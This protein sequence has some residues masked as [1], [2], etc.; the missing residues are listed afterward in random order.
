MRRKKTP[1]T[2]EYVQVRIKQLIEDRKKASDPMDKEWYLR[3]IG[4]LRYVEQIIE[5]NEKKHEINAN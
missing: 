1:S 3:L 5:K 2:K 4:E